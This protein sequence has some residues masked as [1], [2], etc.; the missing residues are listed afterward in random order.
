[1]LKSAIKK[2]FSRKQGVFKIGHVYIRQANGDIKFDVPL[3]S[4]YELS[5][6]HSTN[7]LILMEV[8]IK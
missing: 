5:I 2:L 6:D 4:L 8:K 7:Q 3:E 1:M